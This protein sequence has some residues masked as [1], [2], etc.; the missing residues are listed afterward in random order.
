MLQFQGQPTV[1]TYF[2]AVL[3]NKCRDK[4]RKLRNQTVWPTRVDPQTGKSI[5]LDPPSPDP[6]PQ[7]QVLDREA[8]SELKLWVQSI[9]EHIPELIATLAP[10]DRVVLALRYGSQGRTISWR[11]IAGLLDL[12]VDAAKRTRDRL[13]TR[14]ETKWL[15]RVF[16]ST[17][18]THSSGNVVP[19]ILY[20]RLCEGLSRPDI[21]TKLRIDRKDVTRTLNNFTEEFM[22]HLSQQHDIHPDSAVYRP[23]TTGARK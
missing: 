22:R 4:I 13:R 5:R 23:L 17:L 11:K 9:D 12:T 18:A 19:T 8:N 10:K 16:G 3:Q 6:S 20:L 15:P 2:A 7:Q 21:A 1:G 14:I